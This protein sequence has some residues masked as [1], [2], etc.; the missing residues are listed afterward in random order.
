MPGLP[1]RETVT[2]N[3]SWLFGVNFIGV[4]RFGK[5]DVDCGQGAH[6]SVELLLVY[7]HLSRKRPQNAVYFA[8]LFALDAAPAV[9]DLHHVQRF[10]KYCRAAGGL[11]MH[12]AFHTTAK[13]GFHRQDVAVRPQ[14]DNRVLQVGEILRRAHQGLHAVEQLVMHRAHV[15]AQRPQQR[16]GAIQHVGIL[17]NRLLDGALQG[18]APH[19]LPRQPG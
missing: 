3:D 5:N 14:R 10:H 11:I 16:T 12:D 6:V 2:G 4:A 17:S 9:I 13:L 19:D 7:A 1:K 18:I 15:E 8:F